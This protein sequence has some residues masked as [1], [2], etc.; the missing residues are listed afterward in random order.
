MLDMKLLAKKEREN[1]QTPNPPPPPPGTS[2]YP[3]RYP[4]PQIQKIKKNKGKNRQTWPKCT[5]FIVKVPFSL[6]RAVFWYKIGIYAEKFW[7]KKVPP[8]T[9]E[10]TSV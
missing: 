10:L 6:R 3:R 4:P 8:P 9:L 7:P 2:P 5:N 1:K